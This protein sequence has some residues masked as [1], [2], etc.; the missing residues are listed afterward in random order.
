MCINSKNWIG[1]VWYIK[2]NLM[3]KLTF[4]KITTNAIL[5]FLFLF[6]LTGL[7]IITPL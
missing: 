7:H 2:E 5:I 1:I 6:L 4:D 3:K